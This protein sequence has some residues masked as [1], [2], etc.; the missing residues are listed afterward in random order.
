MQN[1][2]EYAEDLNA[3]RELSEIVDQATREFTESLKQTEALQSWGSQLT[4]QGVDYTRHQARC[5]VSAL[6]AMAT[7]DR[8]VRAITQGDEDER[9]REFAEGL[10]EPDEDTEPY[11][12]NQHYLQQRCA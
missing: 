8:V 11:D 10:A 2:N 3:L 12:D 7:D 6:L 4:A 5:M 1:D 9:A